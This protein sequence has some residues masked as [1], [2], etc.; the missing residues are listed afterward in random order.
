MRVLYI[1]TKIS[2]PKIK[3]KVTDGS[4]NEKSA[5]KSDEIILSNFISSL[6]FQG[7]TIIHD[8]N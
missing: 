2:H 1:K 3:L 6:G 5:Y 4:S 7:T 8:L